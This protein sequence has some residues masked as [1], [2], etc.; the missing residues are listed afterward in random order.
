MLTLH[1]VWFYTSSC[2]DDPWGDCIASVKNLDYVE[3]LHC[4]LHRSGPVV[5]RNLLNAR[6][7]CVLA[8]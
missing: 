8:L 4:D 7:S 3:G 2:L 6:L 1:K 5:L